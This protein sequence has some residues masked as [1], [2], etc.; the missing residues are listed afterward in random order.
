M[1]EMVRIMKKLYGQGK[2]LTTAVVTD[3]RFSGT[4]NGC[5]VGH[6]SPEAASGGP[7][8]LVRDG[9]RITIDIPNGTLTMDVS[10][11]ELSERRKT[12]KE[13]DNGY[14]KGYLARYSRMVGSAAG[15]AVIE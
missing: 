13:H 12:L 14:H 7:I 2:A 3:G 4:N 5:F 9:D 15:G 11:E 8:A 6:V 1:R 10:D